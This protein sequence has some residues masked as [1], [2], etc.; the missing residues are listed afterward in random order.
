MNMSR[1]K[2]HEGKVEEGQGNEDDEGQK[3]PKEG[4]ERACAVWP[5]RINK[6]LD[7]CEVARFQ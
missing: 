5:T 7:S 6:E 1:R 2:N 4:S 3:R